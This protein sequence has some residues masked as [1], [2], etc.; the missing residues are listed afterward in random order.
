MYEWPLLPIF[1]FFYDPSAFLYFTVS[2][3]LLSFIDCNLFLYHHICSYLS[4]YSCGRPAPFTERRG[5]FSLYVIYVF[6]I[7]EKLASY[8]HICPYLLFHLFC[9]SA[10][11]SLKSNYS[12]IS[13][14]VHITPAP[15]RDRGIIILTIYIWHFW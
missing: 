10:S 1:C 6:D 2:C 3:S 8:F 4:V 11:L 12:Y 15:V 9:Q 13:I 5:L 14:F 7:S